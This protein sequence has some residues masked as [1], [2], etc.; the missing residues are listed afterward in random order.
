MSKF[1]QKESDMRSRRVLQLI[2]LTAII[3]ITGCSVSQ[4]ALEESEN[5]INEL[6]QMG[7]PD[8]ALSK[9]KV[10][11]YQAKDAVQ[12]GNTGL[13][14][15]SYDST[16]FYI[17][18]AEAL[19]K[20]S[21]DKIQPEIASIKSNINSFKTKLSGLQVKKIDSLMVPIDSLL[22]IKWILNAHTLI[23][24]LQARLPSLESDQAKADMLKKTI[25][26]D[27]VCENITKGQEI[28]EIHAVEKKIFSLSRD[29][30]AKLIEN[31]KGQSGQ[32]LK[33]DYEFISWG[34]WDMLGDTICLFI[35]RFASVRQN[36]EKLYVENGKKVWKKEPQPTYDS[37]IT[38]GSQDRFITYPDLK[39]DFK[40]AKKF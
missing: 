5:R 30:K 19:Y 18:Q 14:N 39:E 9:A 15:K 3:G 31:K 35:N 32:Y 37:L 22:N 11:V 1:K 23:L 27:W 7:V 24:D 36:F 34:T 16:K 20:E 8:S 10:Y 28:K 17:A 29:G 40:Q 21:L 33:E 25:P 4:K 2:G 6:R 38:D 12:R 13:A 26:G